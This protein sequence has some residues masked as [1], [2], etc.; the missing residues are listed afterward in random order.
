MVLSIFVRMVEEQKNELKSNILLWFSIPVIV[1][2]SILVLMLLYFPGRW[3]MFVFYWGITIL[4]TYI[5]W[6]LIS[7][8]I[9][10][11]RKS[12]PGME[13]T[14]KR[15]AWALIINLII[16]TVV[17]LGINAVVYNNPFVYKHDLVI[18]AFKDLSFIQTWG[19][20]M[21]NTGFWLVIVTAVW[22]AKYFF[23]HY[24]SSIEKSERLK[25]LQI[26]SKLNALKN[27][28]NPHFLFNSLTTLSALIHEDKIKAARFVDHLSIVYRYLLKA[29]QESWIPMHIEI[30]FIK[31]YIF[32][33][34]Q[35]FGTDMLSVEYAFS[36]IIRS[37]D[38]VPPLSLQLV[39]DRIIRTQNQPLSIHFKNDAESIYIETKYNPKVRMNEDEE[40]E[41]KIFNNLRLR[42]EITEDKLKF[43]IPIYTPDEVL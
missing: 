5:L 21:L 26:E 27:K 13:N 19:I 1:T 20:N 43:R 14:R 23:N 4:Y 25:K 29:G 16:C 33:L 12:Y 7:Q 40:N 6:L 3:D 28:V 38:H 10:I 11:T 22:E 35:R 2:T 9:L 8:V 17:Q 18:Q 24:K 34:Q 39:M 36:E 15:I 42:T 37:A 31:K 32:L 30:D 41:N